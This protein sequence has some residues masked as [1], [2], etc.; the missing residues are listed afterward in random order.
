MNSSAKQ[1]GLLRIQL[2]PALIAASIYAVVI[3]ILNFLGVAIITFNLNDEIVYSGFD[4]LASGAIFMG[5]AAANGQN[6][7]FRLFIQN[8][9]TR[10]E[11]YVSNVIGF[12]IISAL[13]AA[14]VLSAV[15]ISDHVNWLSFSM[16]FDLIYD[17]SIS[18]FN[19]M[20]LI[21][22]FNLAVASVVYMF[23]LLF[24]RFDKRI[25]GFG[26]VLSILVIITIIMVAIQILP[27]ESMA[28]ILINVLA[29][30]GIYDNHTTTLNPTI[31]FMIFAV[32]SL[33][34]SRFIIR[35]IE[36]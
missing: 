30:F 31:T 27:N 14:I 21:F 28:A 5:F 19:A 3:I 22:S 29:A 23:I 32:V 11:I 25:V 12:V 15:F 33:I 2:K 9:F 7:E 26:I 1:L 35:R 36:I 24:S 13:M 20:P 4:I 17:D 10:F 16:M 6:E 18:V 34:L 8:C